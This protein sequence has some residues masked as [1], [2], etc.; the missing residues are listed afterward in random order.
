MNYF[1][2]KSIIYPDGTCAPTNKSNR[3]TGF[4]LKIGKAVEPHWWISTCQKDNGK[5][6]GCIYNNSGGPG[7]PVFSS[8]EDEE[9]YYKTR[10]NM[11]SPDFDSE[12]ELVK[13]FE[14]ELFKLCESIVSDKIKDLNTQKKSLLNQLKQFGKK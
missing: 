5:Y 3:I 13:W 4:K 14:Q 8:K 2:P 12:E 11:R 9:F 6:T 10:V 1:P 7:I